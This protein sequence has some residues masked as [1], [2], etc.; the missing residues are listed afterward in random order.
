MGKILG[1]YAILAALALGSTS[2]L[3]ATQF[4]VSGDVMSVGESNTALSPTSFKVTYVYD[5][6]VTGAPTTTGFTWAGSIVSVSY[7]LTDAGGTAVY[8]RDYAP[9]AGGTTLMNYTTTNDTDQSAKW[10]LVINNGGVIDNTDIDLSSSS[11][12]ASVGSGNYPDPGSL[13]SP[14]GTVLVVYNDGQGNY[15]IVRGNITKVTVGP[16]D[17]DGDGIPDN[18]DSCPN[19]DLSSTVTVNGIDTGVT[20]SVQPDGCSIMDLIAGVS[21]PHKMAH[22]LDRL[23]DTGVITERQK[24]K[25]VR[26]AARHHGRHAREDLSWGH[27]SRDHHSKDRDHH[28]RD[29]DEG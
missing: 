10:A 7:Q 29:H 27:H 26:A 11:L 8:S 15:Y 25:I 5:A 23:E 18:Q 19:S 4:T 22:V 2:V 24:G 16:G 12:L 21:S 28:S 17:S 13:V 6:S 1:K 20:N 9:V 14:G 3:A